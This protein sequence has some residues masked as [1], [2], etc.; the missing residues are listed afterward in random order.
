MNER[1]KYSIEHRLVL[2]HVPSSTP[3][4]VCVKSGLGKEWSQK[5]P[6]PRH[7]AI[8]NLPK[9]HAE[10]LNPDHDQPDRL[11]FLLQI[12]YMKLLF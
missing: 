4:V 12:Y 7:Q 2:H 8:E 5:A 9:K 1:G 3:A 10:N 6:H 11:A